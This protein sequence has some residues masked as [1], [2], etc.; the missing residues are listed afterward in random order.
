MHLG[1]ALHGCKLRQTF[2]PNLSDASTSPHPLSVSTYCRH[3]DLPVSLPH[4]SPAMTVMS[5]KGIYS[6]ILRAQEK[7]FPSYYHLAVCPSIL[8]WEV[9]WFVGKI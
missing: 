5:L 1:D 2:P 8:V 9:V 4:P 7:G 6:V 3:C